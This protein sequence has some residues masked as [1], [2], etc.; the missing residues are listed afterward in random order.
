MVVKSTARSYTMT[1]TSLVQDPLMIGRKDKRVKTA[2]SL[3][4]SVA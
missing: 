2:Q 1:G 4:R 3:A